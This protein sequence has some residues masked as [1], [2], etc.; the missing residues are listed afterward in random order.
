MRTVATF[1]SRAFNTSEEKDDF[2]NPGNFGDDLAKWLMGRLREASIETDDE[3]G[4][5]DFGWYFEFTVPEGRHC[6]VLGHR[7]GEDEAV[8]EWVAWL[9]RSR[10]LLASL[11]GGRNR[12]I[13]PAAVAA[14]HAALSGREVE[15]I[16]WHEKADFDAGREEQ[17]SGTP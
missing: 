7:P 12:G 17:G 4:Q 10:G 2:I 14:I 13:A 8:G 11:L 3:P 6:C 1:R 5:E 16:R 9:E 15:G